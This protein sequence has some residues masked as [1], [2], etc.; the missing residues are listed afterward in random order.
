MPI[1]QWIRLLSQFL[2]IVTSVTLGTLSWAALGDTDASIEIDRAQMKGTVRITQAQAYAVHEITSEHGVVVREFVSPG[3]EVFAVAWQGPFIPDLPQ[4]LGKHFDAY[5]QAA[6]EQKAA[7][8]GRRPLNVQ[9]PGLV[10]QM[11]GHMRAYAGRAYLPNRLPQGVAA[12]L[13][14]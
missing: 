10:V 1:L 6:R 4:L 9:L 8:V 3:G 14:R 5:A 13:I 11:S 7:Y 12:D 2:L